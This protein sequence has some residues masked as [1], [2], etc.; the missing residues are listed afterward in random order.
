MAYKD[1]Q[2]SVTGLG[3]ASMGVHGVEPIT[4]DSFTD[5]RFVGFTVREDATVTFKD[6]NREGFF[7]QKTNENYPA[8][9][10]VVGDIR[11]LAVTAGRIDAYYQSGERTA[12]DS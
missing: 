1:S 6:Y 9:Y 7:G 12:N 8:G 11:D 10:M 2:T 4:D 5:K 3:L